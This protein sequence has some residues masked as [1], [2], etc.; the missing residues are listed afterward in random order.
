MTADAN[1]GTDPISDLVDIYE[2]GDMLEAEAIRD[3]LAAEGIKCMIEGGESTG[4]LFDGVESLTAMKI[5]VKAADVER[6]GK[7]IDEGDWPRYA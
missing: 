5:L 1:E 6:A 4:A 7:I 2:P 3:A